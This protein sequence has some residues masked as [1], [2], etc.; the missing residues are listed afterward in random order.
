[1]RAPLPPALL[2]L[3]LL[4]SGER[5]GPRLQN[6]PGPPLL[7][8]RGRGPAPLPSDPAAERALAGARALPLLPSPRLPG[9]PRHPPRAPGGPA[10]VRRTARRRA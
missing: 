5:P 9:A 1:M 6:A 8:A 2:S 3:L 10:E 7:P 4:G